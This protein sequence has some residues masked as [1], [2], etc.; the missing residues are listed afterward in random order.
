M[1]ILCGQSVGL[2]Q[3]EYQTSE[4][5]IILFKVVILKYLSVTR[6]PNSAPHYYHPVPTKAFLQPGPDVAMLFT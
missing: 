3:G 1:V 4:D 2:L 6:Q 5:S